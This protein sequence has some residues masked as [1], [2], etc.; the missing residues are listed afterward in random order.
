MASLADDF[1]GSRRRRSIDEDSIKS[2]PSS[3]ELMNRL[4]VAPK[5]TDTLETLL[6]R[7][8]SGSCDW[9]LSNNVLG[10]FLSDQT[11]Q[12]SILNLSGAPGSGKSVMA[13]FLVQHLESMSLRTQYWYFS[14]DDQQNRSSRQCLLSLAFQAMGV[15]PEF[16]HRVLTL[17]SG[18]DSIARSDLR[19]LWQKL[20][21]NILGKLGGY[22]PLYWVIDAADECES[23]QAFLALLGSLKGLRFPLRIIFTSRSQ[24]I[25]KHVDRLKASMPPGRVLQ[26]VAE[27]PQPS[28][29]LSISNELELAPWP[30]DLKESITDNLLRKSQGNFLWISLVVRELVNC[31]TAEELQQVLEE[32]PVELLDIYERI[33]S[34]V[35]RDLK[36]SDSQLVNALLSWIVCCERV[37]TEDELK[38]ALKPKFSLLNLRHTIGRLCGDL[39]VI[40]KRGY[41]SMVHHTAKDFVTKSATVLAVDQRQAHTLI[42][43]RCLADLTDSRFRLRLRSSGCVGLLRYIC[44]SW[45]HHMVNSDEAG[46]SYDSVRRLAAFFRSQSVLAWIAA[47]S[48]AGQ[49]KVL[50]STAKSITSYV[51]HVQA[52]HADENPLTIPVLE[53]ELLNTWST[54]LI[55]VLGKFGA[56]LLHHP[57]CIYNL[58]PIFCPPESAI[59]RQF[60]YTGPSVPRINGL[61]NT[62]WDDSL[63]KFTIE[64]GR[65]A[66]AI[67]GLDGFFGIVTSN[68]SLNLY[69][70]S[71]FQEVTK[72]RHHENIVAA[73]FSQDGTLLVTCGVRTIKIWDIVT[74][75]TLQI[76]SNPAGVRAMD[77]SFSQDSEAVIVCCV[78]SKIW[79]QALSEQEEWTQV[80]LQAHDEPGSHSTRSGGGTPICTAFSPDGSKVVV[81]YRT[82]PVTIWDTAS[83]NTIGR[84]ESRQSSQNVDYPV[85]LTW[86]PVTEHVAGTFTSGT[87]FKWYPLDLEH[88]AMRTNVMATEIACSPDGRLLVTSQR[89]GS[90]KIFGFDS[91]TLLYNLSCASRATALAFSPDGRRIYDTRG[92][93]CNVWEP[94]ALIRMAD[95]DDV[96]RNSDASSSQYDPSVR[97][98]VVSEATAVTL[99]PVTAI[100]T[101]AGSAAFAFGNDG[102]EVSYFPPQPA[103]TQIPEKLTLSCGLLGITCLAIDRTG[104]LIATASTDRKITV[105]RIVNGD[106]DVDCIFESKIE[107]PVIQLVFAS[108]GQHL[109]IKCQDSAQVWSLGRNGLVLYNSDTAIGSVLPSFWVPHPFT[110]DRLVAVSP[111]TIVV[112]NPVDLAQ[113]QEYRVNHKPD[114]AGMGPDAPLP[115]SRRRSSA[116]Y[117]DKDDLG[118][119]VDHVMSVPSHSDMLVQLSE[120]L[121]SSQLRRVRYVLLSLDSV[122]SPGDGPASI[123]S[124][125]LPA[126]VS[127]TMVMPLGFVTADGSAGARDVVQRRRSSQSTGAAAAVQKIS[128]AFVDRD[129]WVRSWSMDEEGD[130]AHANTKRHFFL[131]RDWINMESLELAQ[132]TLDGRLLC[133]RNGEVAVVHNAFRGHG[134][135]DQG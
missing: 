61:S 28:L 84:L 133:P 131:P 12:P 89:D 31:D 51:K 66:K 127:S 24:T 39:V 129:F 4:G 29:R 110:E 75:R 27:T 35:A 19:S 67:Y 47:V 105:R 52:Q 3:D 56:Q 128:L 71:T 97:G 2:F 87:V 15:F 135:V 73:Q 108:S 80:S 102:G 14:Y 18:I 62:G 101:C 34:A 26:I 120:P 36:A 122:S 55:R 96:D 85:R 79:R 86:N 21:L 7:C 48:S 46:H 114:D 58:V 109:A 33:E 78:D 99:E 11:D 74:S 93:A 43:N 94:N 10:S 112:F 117:L 121:K 92:P 118:T 5:P 38:E 6:E 98:S 125:P 59:A 25:S 116:W 16:S 17:T 124:R 8:T 88:E 95:Q 23:S 69:S 123:Q 30:E 103:G 70:A 82:A 76:Y 44:H 81:A 37:L 104:E 111:S 45:A 90:L 115:M 130:S 119:R 60:P 132:A 57:S 22:D 64:Q 1:T 63:A 83:G 9:I 106:V 91:F 53:I 68:K 77:V 107:S 42:F 49:L 65:R 54:E 13:S 72:L 41:I 126:S 134:W 20:F 50:A 32:T 40:D 100:C 113:W